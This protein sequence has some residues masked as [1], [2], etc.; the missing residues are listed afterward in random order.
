MPCLE[1]GGGEVAPPGIEFQRISLKIG[2]PD[3]FR[4][5]T[6]TGI[7][8][9]HQVMFHESDGVEKRS[10]RTGSRAVDG[11]GY[12]PLG[13]LSRRGADSAQQVL[14]LLSVAVGRVARSLQVL[15]ILE[16]LLGRA[17][18]GRLGAQLLDLRRVAAVASLC[19]P[20]TNASTVSSNPSLQRCFNTRAVAEMAHVLNKLRNKSQKPNT[21]LIHNPPMAR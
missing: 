7:R 18:H 15:E 13:R 19:V 11:S 21:Q 12:M 17:S 14:Q 3:W 16:D 6:G 4:R 20:S 10:K 2:T 8:G 5:G 9:A 1:G